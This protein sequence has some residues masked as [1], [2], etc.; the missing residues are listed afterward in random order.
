M[1]SAERHPQVLVSARRQRWQL[2]WFLSSLR[3]WNHLPVHKTQAVHLKCAT[4]AVA[5]WHCSPHHLT[6]VYARVSTQQL[7]G[8]IALLKSVNKRLFTFPTHVE[9][10]K[11]VVLCRFLSFTRVVLLYLVLPLPCQGPLLVPAERRKR[12]RVG[13]VTGP[14]PTPPARYTGIPRVRGT[15]ATRGEN[16]FLLTMKPLDHV[17]TGKVTLL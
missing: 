3:C 5:S 15:E 7:N 17:T 13:G 6:N 12:R 10:W 11:M 2:R 9:M 1:S 14:L 8:N 16:D 4:T